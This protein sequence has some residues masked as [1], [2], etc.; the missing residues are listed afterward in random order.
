MDA[1]TPCCSQVHPNHGALQSFF[2]PIHYR[3]RCQ[4]E[5][6]SGQPDIP[7]PHKAVTGT[8]PFS[9]VLLLADQHLSW[10]CSSSIVHR[11]LQAC[12]LQAGYEEAI[13]AHP[14]GFHDIDALSVRWQ[15]YLP[16]ASKVFSFC[17]MLSDSVFFVDIVLNFLTGYVP[18]RSSVP[19]YGLKRIALNYIQDTFVFDAIATFPWELVQC[20][21]C[22]QPHVHAF[23]NKLLL[24][25]NLV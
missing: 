2:C 4:R 18:R 10:Y 24:Q 22:C 19:E 12:Q 14:T 6:W 23:R 13:A 25:A 1:L 5:L 8:S 15:V 7:N 9:R 17:N 3:F 20:P 11:R 21:P 16:C